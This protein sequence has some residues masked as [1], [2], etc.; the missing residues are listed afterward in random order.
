MKFAESQPQPPQ[1]DSERR[2]G[3]GF[4]W[5]AVSGKLV[6][7][8]PLS[9]L[10][11]GQP[12]AEPATGSE[13]AAA[14]PPDQQ[15]FGAKVL[16]GGRGQLVQQHVDPKRRPQID[17]IR[18]LVEVAWRGHPARQVNQRDIHVAPAAA[19]WLFQLHHGGGRA[20]PGV[21]VGAMMRRRGTHDRAAVLPGQPDQQH[22]ERGGLPQ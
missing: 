22:D 9:D 2:S 7:S 18:S 6:R 21:P 5:W 15:L 8:G 3:S 1:T 12:R 19:P 16:P 13:A 10:A 11:G 20:L 17:P 14:T 4:V